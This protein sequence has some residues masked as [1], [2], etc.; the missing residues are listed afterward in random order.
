MHTDIAISIIF[1]ITYD[2]YFIIIIIIIIF[3]QVY[4]S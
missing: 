2:Q 1:N 4:N 3:W